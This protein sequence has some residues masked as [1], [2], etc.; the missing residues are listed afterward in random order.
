MDWTVDAFVWLVAMFAIHFLWLD[1]RKTWALKLPWLWM[2]AL[3]LVPPMLPIAWLS[4]T[5]ETVEKSLL[6]PVVCRAAALSSG[7][8]S[9]MLCLACSR[10]TGV[11]SRISRQWL[12]CRR[13]NP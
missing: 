3:L 7:L 2:V 4:I 12:K 11:L 9:L 5:H 8:T 6:W 1:A 13:K 10:G